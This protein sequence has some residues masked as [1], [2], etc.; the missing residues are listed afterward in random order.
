M[1]HS[2]DLPQNNAVQ[3]YVES[4]IK[5]GSGLKSEVRNKPE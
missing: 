3:K 5:E 4:E 1:L 2:S